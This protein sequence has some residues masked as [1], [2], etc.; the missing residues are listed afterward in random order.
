MLYVYSKNP[1]HFDEFG[2]T[3]LLRTI[4]SQAG[5]ALTNAWAEERLRLHNQYMIALVRASRELSAALK[6]EE[7]FEIAWRFVKEELGISIFYIALYDQATGTL[8]FPIYYDLNTL[9][10]RES[11]PRDTREKWG[12]TGYVHQYWRRGILAKPD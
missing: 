12:V 2:H 8:S 7:M 3:T 5:L 9:I 4:A 1:H 10:Q 11:R 6:Q